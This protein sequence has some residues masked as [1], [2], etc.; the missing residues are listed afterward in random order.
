MAIH[1]RVVLGFSRRNCG[2]RCAPTR[3]PG[4]GTG[5]S[6]KIGA[7]LTM[8]RVKE[9]PCF[10]PVSPHSR[11]H[12]STST[13]AIATSA[14]SIV[15]APHGFRVLAIASLLPRLPISIR[16]RPPKSQRRKHVLRQGDRKKREERE[17][18]R[19]KCCNPP[20]PIMAWDRRASAASYHL[21]RR[22]ESRGGIGQPLPAG[23]NV[24][25]SRILI[26]S[27]F[28]RIIPRDLDEASNGSAHN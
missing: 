28:L 24:E 13:I 11:G 20:A 9:R 19:E 5:S 6:R 4:F 7:E 14:A 3:I 8:F 17:R 15:T 26:R 2:D 23:F 25:Y 12:L 10:L 22:K 21:P 18:E 1:R 27:S 16:R